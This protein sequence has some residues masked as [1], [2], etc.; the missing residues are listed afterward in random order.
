MTAQVSSEN[1]RDVGRAILVGRG[2]DAIVSDILLAPVRR[3]NRRGV[4]N[5]KVIRM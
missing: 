5:A 2:V 3:L 4:V 1:F